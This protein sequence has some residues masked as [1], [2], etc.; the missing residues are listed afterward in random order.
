MGTWVRLVEDRELTTGCSCVELQGWSRWSGGCKGSYS[1]LGE[2]S[3]KKGLWWSQGMHACEHTRTYC[4]VHTLA[5]EPYGVWI[6][7]Q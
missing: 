4:I 7:S 2:G 6:I 3:R 1:L 5:G